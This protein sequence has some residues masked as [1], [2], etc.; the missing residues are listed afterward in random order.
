MLIV[1]L[2]HCTRV[3]ECPQGP[4]KE[5][6]VYSYD[7]NHGENVAWTVCSEQQLSQ[8]SI[9]LS[10]FMPPSLPLSLSLPHP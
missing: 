5:A 10:G 6:D 3:F 1:Q 8:A 4:S 7:N 9:I 2:V